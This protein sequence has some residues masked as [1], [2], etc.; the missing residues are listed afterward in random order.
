[1]DA[2]RVEAVMSQILSDKYGAEVSCKTCSQYKKCIERRGICASYDTY[3]AVV[4]RAREGVE[5][6]NQKKAEH[7]AVPADKGGEYRG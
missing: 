6:A 7:A 5:S 4:Q 3:D 1:M 2:A